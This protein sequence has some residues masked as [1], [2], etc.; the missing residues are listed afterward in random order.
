MLCVRRSQYDDLMEGKSNESLI[1]DHKPFSS[2]PAFPL[3]NHTAPETAIGDS[4]IARRDFSRASRRSG[5]PQP[6]LFIIEVSKWMWTLEV[7]AIRVI[8]ERELTIL[9][10]SRSLIR[11]DC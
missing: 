6:L 8:G 9:A 5:H 7:N 4:A 11:H 3:G 1:P 10:H 2:C